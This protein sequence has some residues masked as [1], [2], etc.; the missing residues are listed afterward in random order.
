MDE[1]HKEKICQLDKMFALQPFL[2]YGKSILGSFI[3][4]IQGYH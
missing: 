3:A 4:E 1:F 2:P